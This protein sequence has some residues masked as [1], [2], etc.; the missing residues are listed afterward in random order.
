MGQKDYTVKPCER[1]TVQAALALQMINIEY[2]HHDSV[3]MI[4]KSR[5][6]LVFKTGRIRGKSF[7]LDARPAA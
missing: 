2:N 1:Q 5:M 3:V 6:D 7:L 4:L